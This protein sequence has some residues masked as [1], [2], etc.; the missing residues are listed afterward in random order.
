MNAIPVRRWSTWT[1]GLTLAAVAVLAPANPAQA[2]VGCEVNYT[3]SSWSTGFV[4]N[5]QIKNLGETWVA[6]TVQFTFTGNQE[7]IG[8]WGYELSQNGAQVTGHGLAWSRP[9]PTGATLSLGFTARYTGLNTPPTNWRVNGALCVLPGQPPAVIAEP[10]SLSVPEGSGG[11]FTV[12]LSHPPAEATYLRMTT[13]GTGVWASPPVML[14]FNSTNWSTP[15]SFGVYSVQDQDT[16]D[17]VLVFTLAYPG[18]VSDTVTITQ[19]DD[20]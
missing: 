17:D 8:G 20:D 1:C 12:R 11:S 9:I 15:Q 5:V 16:V 13:R 18:Y 3:T 19:V 7:I 14:T 2:A 10:T 4:G 6:P